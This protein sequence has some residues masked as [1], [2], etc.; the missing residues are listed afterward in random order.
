MWG[1]GAKV[2]DNSPPPAESQSQ[3]QVHNEDQEKT[4]SNTTAPDTD[5]DGESLNKD[6]RL[7]L[8][9]LHVLHHDVE[10]H[11]DQA[12]QTGEGQTSYNTSYS[13]SYIDTTTP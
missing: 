12:Q 5:S 13:N 9:C 10:G 2:W 8:G 6:G 7:F 11:F 1:L 4:A 3:D